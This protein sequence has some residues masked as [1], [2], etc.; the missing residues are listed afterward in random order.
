MNVEEENVVCHVKARVTID[1]ESKNSV[2]PVQ[3]LDAFNIA[4]EQL[5]PFAVELQ[6]SNIH[7]DEV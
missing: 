2:P 4:L 5:H 1:N 3:V 7:V 6:N